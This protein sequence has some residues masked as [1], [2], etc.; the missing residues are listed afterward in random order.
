MGNRV[1][2]SLALNN[3]YFFAGAE[4]GI[5]RLRYPETITRVENSQYVPAGFELEQNYP[6][7]FNPSTTINYNIPKTS[8]VTLTVYNILG[9]VVKTLVNNEQPPGNYSVRFIAG[10]KQMASGVYF[11]RLQAG[12]FVRTKKMILLQ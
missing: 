9:G 10:S 3:G 2:Y 8:Q 12:S 11:Y 6:N 1:V 4:D 5:W 7:P